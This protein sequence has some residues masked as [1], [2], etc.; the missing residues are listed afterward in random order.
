MFLYYVPFRIN[1]IA[2]QMKQIIVVFF[3]LLIYTLLL[4]ENTSKSVWIYTV[5]ISNFPINEILLENRNYRR[6]LLSSSKVMY[7]A[8]LAP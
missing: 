7:W 2:F 6:H 3:P 8:Q 1:L 4:G 5:C